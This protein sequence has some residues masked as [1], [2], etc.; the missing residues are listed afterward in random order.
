MFGRNKKECSCGKSNIVYTETIPTMGGDIYLHYCK[1]CFDEKAQ[2][3]IRQ[4]EE[5]ERLRKENEAEKAKNDYYLWL[6]REVEI[7]E[8][9]LKAKEYGIDTKGGT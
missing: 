1:E 3:A 8:L 9:E 4:G 5:R 2:E 7:K 6:K